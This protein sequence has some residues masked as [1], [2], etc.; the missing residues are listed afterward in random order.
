MTWLNGSRDRGGAP[1]PV[2]MTDKNG[3]RF[4]VGAGGEIKPLDHEYN[5]EEV[6]GQPSGAIKAVS[7]KQAKDLVGKAQKDFKLTDERVKEILADAQYAK[8]HPGALNRPIEAGPAVEFPSAFTMAALFCAYHGQPVRSDFKS[9]IESFDE[10]T[11]P[12]PL[13]PDTFYFVQQLPWFKLDAEMGH[14]LIFYGDPNRRQA[15]FVSRLFNLL[16]VAVLMPFDEHE[17][18]LH[19]Y[20]VDI[21][22]GKEVSV[23]VNSADLCGFDWKATHVLGEDLFALNQERG[24]TLMTLAHNFEFDRACK[25]IWDK[26]NS[27]V[28]SKDKMKAAYLDFCELFN[29]MVKPEHRE[30]TINEFKAKFVGLGMDEE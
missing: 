18:V 23:H 28:F 12:R 3:R 27:G 19:T 20:G 1:T 16:E 29:I 4:M 9:Y 11:Q 26:Y 24:Q 25:A 15:I 17:P 8:E 10:N 5:I 2:Q 7:L 6:N 22:K 30:A 13:P 14:S 21:L